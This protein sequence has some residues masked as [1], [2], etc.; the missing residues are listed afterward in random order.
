MFCKIER[1]AWSVGDLSQ[2]VEE[3]TDIDA[4]LNCMDQ[5]SDT[6]FPIAKCFKQMLSVFA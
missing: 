4:T 1:L 6:S 5:P 2:I 3:L